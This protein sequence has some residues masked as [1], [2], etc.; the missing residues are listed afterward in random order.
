MKISLFLNGFDLLYLQTKQY[1]R[2]TSQKVYVIIICAISNKS[3]LKIINKHNEGE[4]LFSILKDYYTFCVDKVYNTS[5][6][7]QTNS[8]NFVEDKWEINEI[9]STSNESWACFLESVYLRYLYYWFIMH[10]FS[11]VLS[12][13]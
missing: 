13:F 6:L 10:C 5:F 8:T 4:T 3:M 12:C 2:D 1:L 7:L 11:V 9:F